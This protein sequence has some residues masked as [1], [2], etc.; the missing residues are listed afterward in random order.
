[1]IAGGRR[2]ENVIKRGRCSS[3]FRWMQNG[4]AAAVWTLAVGMWLLAA[5]GLVQAQTA[6]LGPNL[7][8]NG[9]FE[10]DAD[11]NGKPDGWTIQWMWI[12]P[13][14]RAETASDIASDGKR[15]LQV[16][17]KETGVPEGWGGRAYQ[18]V[19]VVPG[20]AYRISGSIKMKNWQSI[21]AVEGV[22]LTAIWHFTNG[23]WSE[24]PKSVTE[25]LFA[26]DF[27]W[28]RFEGRIVAPEGADLLRLAAWANTGTGE[29]WYDDIRVQE[30]KVT[31]AQAEETNANKALWSVDLETRP[32]ETRAVWIDEFTLAA[33]DGRE[34]VSGLMDNLERAGI[35]VVIPFVSAWGHAMWK[36]DVA[37]ISPE[38]EEWG[39]DPLQ[40]IVEEAHRRGIEVHA[41]SI[42]FATGM[43]NNP[44]PIAEAHPDWVE[45]DINGKNVSSYGLTWLSPALQEVQDFMMAQLKELVSRYDIDGL[46]LD[47]IRYEIAGKTPFGYNPK[48]LALYQQETGVDARKIARGSDEEFA[49][50]RWRTNQVTKFVE[51]AAKELKAIKPHVLLSAAVGAD[52]RA[53]LSDRYQDWKLWV[54][55]G[56]LDLVFPM[57]Y[58]NNVNEVRDWVKSELY[59]TKELAGGRALTYIGLGSYLLQQPA[60][61]VQQIELT[62]QLGAAGNALFCTLQLDPWDY[63]A[64]AEGPYP[65]PAVPTHRA[66]GAAAAAIL[67]SLAETVAGSEGAPDQLAA[68]LET[69]ASRIDSQAR[70]ASLPTAAGINFTR[71]SLTKVV[72]D[73]KPTGK[74]A[75]LMTEETANRLLTELSVV[76]Q[77]LVYWSYHPKAGRE[78]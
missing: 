20:K 73:L 3:R 50:T 71:S 66:P 42:I 2:E 51:R 63:D 21:V 53:A 46:Q 37:P 31:A 18:D 77:L 16:T 32:A 58:S 43:E 48:A 30:E 56:Y 1:M 36:S 75:P 49:F 76:D 8:K 19:P 6:E 52:Y 34:G 68:N 10:E 61:I 40:V 17:V 47:Y 15:S 78:K 29:I 5:S 13:P 38:V 70:A 33:L 54:E 65:Y 45:L 62:R 14:N 11:G 23:S 55:K 9:S 12:K 26:G 7:V 60:Q 72:N 64:L 22:S 27:D 44:G 41:I 28:K 25:Q 57:A 39:E 59:I 74:W 67:R 4:R 35:N 24:T 69:L